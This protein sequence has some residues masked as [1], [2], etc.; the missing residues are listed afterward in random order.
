ML[1]PR[2]IRGQDGPPE[3]CRFADLC[4]SGGSRIDLARAALQLA[5]ALRI[6]LASGIE[7]LSTSDLG[8][9]CVFLRKPFSLEQLRE[10]IEAVGRSPGEKD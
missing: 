1:H 5:P 7:P 2:C 3:T 8:F 4:L 10:L 6:G 9:E